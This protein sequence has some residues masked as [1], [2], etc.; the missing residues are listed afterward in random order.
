M[1]CQ[2]NPFLCDRM[3]NDVKTPRFYFL[4]DKLIFS[5]FFCKRG[6]DDGFEFETC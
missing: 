5:D 4:N 3:F 1:I 2:L 6:E